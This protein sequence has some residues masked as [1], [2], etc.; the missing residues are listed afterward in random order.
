MPTT[1]PA[2]SHRATSGGDVCPTHLIADTPSEQDAFGSHRRIA[3]AI[4]ELMRTSSGGR[5]IGLSGTWGSGKSTVVQILRELCQGEH[6]VV[7]IFDAWAHEGDPLRRT[8]LESLIAELRTREWLT[9]STWTDKLEILA[10]RRKVTERKSAPRLSGLGILLAVSVLLVPLGTLLFGNELRV[11]PRPGRL[12]GFALL[13]LAPVLALLAYAVWVLLH[14]GRRGRLA[15]EL[16]DALTVFVQR[17][18]TASRT[19]TLDTADPTSLDFERT[20][21]DVMQAAL[22]DHASRRVLMVIDNLDRVGAAQALAIWSTLQTFLRPRAASESWV[23]RFWCLLP[24]DADA[25]R[26]LW[27]KDAT[28]GSTVA[29]SF[30]DKTFQIRFEVPLPLLSNWTDYLTA[31]LKE[32][33]PGHSADEFFRIYRL[34]SV[35]RAVGWPAP[36]PRELKLFVNQVGSLH[37]QWQGD[38][39][40][41]DLA[42]Y[43]LLQ[44]EGISITA[45]LLAGSLPAAG[46]ARLV[47]DGVRQSLAALVY[48]APIDKAQELLLREPILQ[49]LEAPAPDQL[50]ALAESSPVFWSVLEV[51]LDRARQ[52][53]PRAEGGKLLHA[54]VALERSGTLGREPQWR[55]DL[56]F[57]Q[58]QAAAHETAQWVPMDG[59]A[60][61][62]IVILSRREPALAGPLLRAFAHVRAG[63]PA[64]SIATEAD[65]FVDDYLRLVRALAEID[66]ALA[67]VP[68]SV[69]SSAADYARIAGALVAR[70]PEGR[71]WM[72]ILPLD[73]ATLLAHLAQADI[74]LDEAAGV[75]VALAAGVAGDWAAVV[76]NAA[77]RLQ[78]PNATAAVSRP[79]LIVLH[80]LADRPEVSAW[81]EK[82]V[83]QGDAMKRV[84][85]ALSTRDLAAAAPWV[86]TVMR[87]DPSLQAIYSP[88]VAE[89]PEVGQASTWLQGQLV[90]FSSELLEPLAS[91]VLEMGHAATVFDVAERNP[92]ARYTM[93]GVLQTLAQKGAPARVFPAPL[94]LERWNAAFPEYG[95]AW[96]AGAMRE[97]R[98]DI[99]SVLMTQP[100]AAPLSGTYAA[101]LDAGEKVPGDPKF[102]SFCQ[103]GAQGAD[104]AAWETSLAGDEGLVMLVEALARR[105]LTVAV[106]L[107]GAAAFRR[108]VPV[109]AKGTSKVADT[110]RAAV[111]RALAPE[112]RA[113]VLDTVLDAFAGATVPGR[114]SLLGLVDKDAF[115]A[116]RLASRPEALV[117]LARHVLTNLN[118]S[119]VSALAAMLAGTPQTL[120]ALTAEQRRAVRRLVADEQS[121]RQ[122]EEA[123]AALSTLAV[124]F[125]TG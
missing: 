93:L 23:D 69:P 121:K 92:S 30:L 51:A 110:A 16:R 81:L 68:M 36:T 83:R 32:A 34:Y 113:A 18:E 42:Y 88:P 90:S 84:A 14:R 1:C 117:E 103:A 118:D 104:A 53:W 64:K 109:L 95:N 99:E 50:K 119:W 58:L 78:E 67:A 94:L 31:Q 105:G 55:L 85:A 116:G 20:F 2:G 56:L 47:S 115:D 28:S 49:A 59:P 48:G 37:R 4:A 66:P 82:F 45:E 111:F 57:G 86:Y 15:E 106:G 89:T 5:S 63:D 70:D 73:S 74:N 52:E 11:A 97:H 107:G 35:R 102:P 9:G 76:A 27:P 77:R 22:A 112:G 54:A 43:V 80:A 29:E 7:W 71:F 44:R 124:A 91:A 6:Y 65:G 98:A 17:T 101:V 39:P 10:K 122:A 72:N 21:R 75:R 13:M 40:L 38:I 100:F 79:L 41:T 120:A 108:H 87:Q 26:R 60:V 25:I 46:E 62:G 61:D 19:E 125:T 8:F 114:V 24:F 96:V 123:R 3:Q 33:L 12:A